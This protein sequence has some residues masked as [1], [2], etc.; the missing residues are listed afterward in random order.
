MNV[1]WCHNSVIEVWNP[2]LNAISLE[3]FQ[4]FNCHSQQSKIVFPK[5]SKSVAESLCSARAWLRCH[6][7]NDT[8]R[9]M[10]GV[11]EDG[12]SCSL[13]IEHGTLLDGCTGTFPC[14]PPTS[15]DFHEFMQ[16][17]RWFFSSGESTMGT[18]FRPPKIIVIAVFSSLGAFHCRVFI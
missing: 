3:K 5:H 2:N 6:D 15:D 10:R 7:D 13:W 18:L 4:L 11:W 1:S 9:S 12:R 14:H 16:Q 8:I 17:P